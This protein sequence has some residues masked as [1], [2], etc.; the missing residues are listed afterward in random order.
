MNNWPMVMISGRQ[1][2]RAVRKSRGSGDADLCKVVV[3]K[4]NRI[5][6]KTTCCTDGLFRKAAML[7]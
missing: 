4:K 5:I 7:Q 3:Q 6:I 1:V 2:V